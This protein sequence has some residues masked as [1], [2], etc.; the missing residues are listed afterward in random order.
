MPC[1]CVRDA[2]RLAERSQTPI[3]QFLNPGMI[4]M[5]VVRNRLNSLQLARSET[6]TS[7]GSVSVSSAGENQGATFV[8]ELPL[9]P[10]APHHEPPTPPSPTSASSSWM[11][12][13]TCA[14]W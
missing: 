6:V 8:V 14:I 13:R 4:G 12:N 3:E 1:A 5:M 9:T 7:D 10:I 2:V 11:T